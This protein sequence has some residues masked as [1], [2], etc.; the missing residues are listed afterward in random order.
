MKALGKPDSIASDFGED[1]SRKKRIIA[2][3]TP[4]I[5]IACMYPIFNLLA[6]SIDS[7]RIAW[8]LG[9]A[10]YWLIWGLV[11]PI[12]MIGTKSIKE[13]ITPQKL[14]KRILLL[15]SIPL[16][17]SIAAKFVPGMGEYEKESILILILVFSTPFGNGFFEELLWRGVYFK[18][19]PSN[20]FLRMI[21]PSI[22]FGLWHYV[23]VSIG[24]NEIAGLV[25]MMI[26]PLMMGLYFAFLAKKTNTIWWGIVAHTVGGFI[27]VA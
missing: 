23:P 6:S 4:P 17:G 12:L 8:Y 22:W 11:Y 13:I 25:G 1:S 2:I 26:G 14:T 10:T 9:L 16:L 21:W 15:L 27:M 3:L 7:D 24:N 20:L 5:I 19:F 18:L